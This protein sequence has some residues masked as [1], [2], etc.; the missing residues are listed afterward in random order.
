RQIAEAAAVLKAPAADIAERLRALVEE[1]KALQAEVARLRREVAMGASGAAEAPEDLGGTAFL[2]RSLAGVSGKD[3]APMVTAA[4]ERL[5]SGVVL[6]IAETDGKA[7]VAAGVSADLTARFSA[8]DLVRAAAEA[9]GGRGG[10]GRPDFAQG[11]GA[12]AARAPQG[13]AAVRN[14]IGGK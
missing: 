4:R 3:L 9:M 13:I 10:G 12:D 7:A 5:G 11:G 6:F 14:L 2:A 1:R 8:V